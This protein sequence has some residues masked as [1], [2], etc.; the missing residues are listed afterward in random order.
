[1]P[2][3]KV[4]KEG[5]TAEYTPGGDEKMTGKET[6][7]Q[8]KKIRTSGKNS[9]KG[10][11][12]KRKE[13]KK[14][15][16]A[17][18]DGKD[19]N[20]KI[21]GK[22]MLFETEEKTK[23]EDIKKEETLQSR[24]QKE[25]F[26][27]ERTEESEKYEHKEKG[28]SGKITVSYG[29]EINVDAELFKRKSE[30]VEMEEKAAESE[31]QSTGKT[32]KSEEGGEE[33]NKSLELEETTKGEG[34]GRTQKI[35]ESQK[36]EKTD[37]RG[38]EEGN[39]IQKADS[40]SEV[41]QDIEE[42]QGEEK[43]EIRDRPSDEVEVSPPPPPKKRYIPPRLRE[44]AEFEEGGIKYILL[45]K[46]STKTISELIKIARDLRIQDPSSMRRQELIA[47]ILSH[48]YLDYGFR[49][50][51]EGVFQSIDTGSGFLRFP[52]NN[53]LQSSDDV[54]VSKTMIKK[55]GLR[56]GDVVAGEI[57]PPKEDK[58]KYFSLHSIRKINFTDP[59]K[60]RERNLFENLIPYYPRKKF[61]LD[62]QPD[63]DISCRVVDIIAPIGK[64][65]RGLIVSPP[66]AG[67]TM[68]LQN[69]AKAILTNHPE[70]VL[71]V[72]L[73]DERPEEVTDWK[74]NIIGKY[75]GRRVE[76][77]AS[78]FDEKPE[79]HIKVAEI[80][81]AKAKRLVEYK[82][83]VVIFLDSITRLTRA[84]NQ[85]VPSSGKILTGGID[86]AALQFPK[87]FFGAARAIEGGGSLT[88]LATCLIDTG[89]RMDEVIFEEFKGTG[90]ME[91]YLD[92]RIAEKRIFPAID[93]HRSGTRRE[94]LLIPKD[95]LTKVWLLRKVLQP[96]G[97]I[98]A[99][100]LL[101]EKMSRTKTNDEFFRLIASGG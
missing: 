89:S 72:L 19:Q 17:V 14:R 33:D 26:E 24:D 28:N 92:R 62:W 88:I 56:D 71:I 9:K 52:H 37:E 95:T 63:S 27:G 47:E 65:Q 8:G 98:D 69:I 70:V 12:E 90:N 7:K 42:S 64:G 57:K 2:A 35:A 46:V 100:E 23:K 25:I 1:M 30:E 96:L 22:N 83:D 51:A 16:S 15:K 68:L 101:H 10:K 81:L 84:Y 6:E 31:A 55:Y 29:Y 32:E 75:S 36:Y 94:E 20:E 61:R 99:M 48:A 53:Y 3:K 74:R 41:S 93:V 97:T 54:F 38:E 67:K 60:A 40:S 58:G 44:L 49:L 91:I 85:Y 87:K 43:Q 77:I 79:T 18:K 66:R 39:I 21:Q 80:V 45:N 13:G 78:T 5:G 4:I 59:W 82:Y 76:V 11:V 73:I 86:S 50:Y 34:E